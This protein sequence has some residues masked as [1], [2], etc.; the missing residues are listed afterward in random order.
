M[1]VKVARGEVIAEFGFGATGVVA[2]DVLYQGVE[3]CCV[4]DYACA[5]DFDRGPLVDLYVR[6]CLATGMNERR[7]YH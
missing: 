5:E 3:E 7:A 2:A 1:H 4:C 6:G